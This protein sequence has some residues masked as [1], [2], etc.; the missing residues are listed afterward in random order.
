MRGTAFTGDMPNTR[1]YSAPAH[2]AARRCSRGHP[3]GQPVYHPTISSPVARRV[4]GSPDCVLLFFAG[5]S[6][7]FAGIK[8]VDWLVFSGRLLEDPMGGFSGTVGFAR[9]F[10][11]GGPA[12]ATAAVEAICRAHE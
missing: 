10:F 4:W 12:E 2:R 3:G 1:L 9:G 5:G 6:S 7:E 11:F 8:A